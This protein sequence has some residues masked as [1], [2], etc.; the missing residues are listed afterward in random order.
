MFLLLNAFGEPGMVIPFEDGDGG[1][2]QDRAGIQLF[3][4]DVH[5]AAGELHPGLESL[6]D[7][8][9]ATDCLLYTSPS[10]R[11]S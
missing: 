3:G 8:V 9:Q 6:P 4:D 7:G 11:D 10:P 5:R 1:L 2:G